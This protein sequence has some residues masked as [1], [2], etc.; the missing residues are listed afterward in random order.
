MEKLETGSITL[1]Q[2]DRNQ[3]EKLI[4]NILPGGDTVFHRL[5]KKSKGTVIVEILK[6]CHPNLEKAVIAKPEVHIP[7]LENFLGENPIQ[8]LIDPLSQKNVNQ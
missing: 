6:L 2:I 1:S 8:L 5:A 3:F 4:Y 7:F